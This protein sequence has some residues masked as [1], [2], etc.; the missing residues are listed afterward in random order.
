MGPHGS[1]NGDC[2]DG[3]EELVA[4]V[5][6]YALR[7]PRPIGQKLGRSRRRLGIPR[8]AQRSGSLAS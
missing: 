3:A 8:E 2:D 7:S 1:L 4:L 5:R 6:W